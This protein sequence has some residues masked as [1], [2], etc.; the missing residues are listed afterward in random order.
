MYLIDDDGIFLMARN[1]RTSNIPVC[2][3]VLLLSLMCIVPVAAEVDFQVYSTPSGALVSVDN[4]WYDS[5]PAT[6]RD[7][8]SGWHTIRV[9][10]DGYQPNS[11][12]QYCDDSSGGLQTCVVD[13][14]L[15]PNPV[16][17]GWLRITPFSAEVWIDGIDQGN[18]DMTI[19][20]SPGTHT[21]ILRKPG[22]YDYSE[23][24]VIS[25]GET[26]AR[27]PGMTPYPQQPQY[28][29]L[30]IDSDPAGASIYLDNS[31]KGSEPATGAF[32]I[33]D[34]A[35]G[36]YTLR[37]VM[38]DYQTWSQKVQVMPGI[39][40]DIHATLVPNPPGP[41][42]DTTGQIFAYSTPAGANV[43][44]DNS[45]KGITP[46]TL[47][48]IPAGSHTVTF[49]LDGYQDYSTVASVSGGTIINVPAT[50]TPGTR[51]TPTK[52]PVYGVTII[53]S[54]VINGAIF[55]FSRKY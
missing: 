11:Q 17:V 26:T 45:Y 29:S 10:M 50:L 7:V 37:L 33:T 44:V 20:L 21:L 24:F 5:T 54:L 32:Y 14:R 34:L 3:A 18:G 30:Q 13:V 47:R 53:M 52:A 41:T 42:P 31:Y 48:D 8:G 22:Y 16:A 35:P 1:L 9:M 36:T 51:P 4:F 23:T 39:V 49:R 15:I 12:S 6:I 28:G 43:I 38:P 2:A 55:L 46:L 25:A 40:N 27:A 19:P